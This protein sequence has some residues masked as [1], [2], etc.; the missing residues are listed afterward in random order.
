MAKKR[1]IYDIAREAGV[2]PSTVSRVFSG[3]KNV[4]AKTRT[5]VEAIARAYNFTTLEN[6]RQQVSLARQTFAVIIPETRDQYWGRIL[7][8]ANREAKRLGYQTM[9]FQLL[10]GEDYD[11]T[12]IARRII[13]W[14]LRGALYIGGVFEAVRPDLPVALNRL[15]EHMPLVAISPPLDTVKCTFLHND[16]ETAMFQAVQHLHMMGH[17]R[18]AFIGGNKTLAASGARARGYLRAVEEFGLVKDDAYHG[19]AGFTAETGEIAVLRMLTTIPRHR[20]PTAIVA[21]SDLV[22][23]GAIHQLHSMN[24]KLPEDMALIGCDNTYFSPHTLP[25]L[26]T[27]DLF[28]EERARTAIVELVSSSENQK[29]PVT[30]IRAPALIIRESCGAKLGYRDLS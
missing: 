7:S 19:A 11:M 22:A 2:A 6:L 10:D 27:I 3:H 14:R 20:W 15:M 30:L 4:S 13:H 29:A 9:L 26:T 16:L 25:P 12:E 23:V 18:V 1:T 5:K 28:S 24:L 17:R 21:F 8:A